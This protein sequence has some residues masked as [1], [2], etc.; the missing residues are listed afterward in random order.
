MGSQLCRGLKLQ[1]LSRLC[2]GEHLHDVVRR[3]LGTRYHVGG[4]EGCWD[5]G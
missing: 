3:D 4:P 2:G 1:I 5:A